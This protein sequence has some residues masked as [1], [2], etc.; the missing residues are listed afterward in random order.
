MTTRPFRLL[1]I[2]A[3][4]GSSVEA[5]SPAAPSCGD[6]PGVG[7]IAFVGR[8]VD[9]RPAGTAVAP[10]QPMIVD[11]KFLAKYQVLHVICG[12]YGSPQIEFD[13]YDHYGTPAFAGF[14]T[15]LLFV[16]RLNGRLVH[17]KYVYEPVYETEDGTWAG[18]GDP[19]ALETWAPSED[20]HAM[21]IRFKKEVSFPIANMTEEQIGEQYPP[22]YF[23]RRRD[24][25]VC[26]AGTG[27]AELFKVKRS[28]VLTARGLFK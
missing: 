10:G 21:P 24:R 27:I 4:A 1:L 7:L 16:S 26:T 8:L 13:V 19:Y 20:V 5:Q 15:V 23:T 18:C 25:V 11:Q 3:L 2:G 12:A 9:L 14:E 22:Q 6:Q 17:E 28:G